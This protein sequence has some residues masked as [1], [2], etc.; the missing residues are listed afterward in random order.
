MGDPNRQG[1]WKKFQ[2]LTNR[3]QSKWGVGI[4]EKA[5]NDIQGWKEQKQ[6]VIKPKTKRYTAVRYFTMKIGSE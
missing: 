2:N 4:R 5:L 1:G 3:S 6:V